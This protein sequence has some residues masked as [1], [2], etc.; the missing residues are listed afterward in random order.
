MARMK[1][2]L[3]MMTY[4][5]VETYR[6]LYLGSDLRRSS[7]FVPRAGTDKDRMVLAPDI[8]GLVRSA[9]PNVG[10]VVKGFG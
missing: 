1:A 7:L 5:I 6:T 10:F 4:A 3:T 8:C 9:P 2:K